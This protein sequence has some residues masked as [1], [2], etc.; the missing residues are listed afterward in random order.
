MSCT[1]CTGPGVSGTLTD[2]VLH[3]RPNSAPPSTRSA[4]Q[5]QPGGRSQACLAGRSRPPVAAAAGV[6]RRQLS[7]APGSGGRFKRERAYLEGNYGPGSPRSA[8]KA[9]ATPAQR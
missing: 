2:I 6:E 8:R 3:D 4:P 9:A 5:A 1:F 7:E